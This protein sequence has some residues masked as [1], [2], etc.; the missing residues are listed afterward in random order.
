MIA[1]AALAAFDAFDALG[2]VCKWFGERD[3]ESSWRAKMEKRGDKEAK[4]MQN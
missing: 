1:L 2:L 3:L 4:W